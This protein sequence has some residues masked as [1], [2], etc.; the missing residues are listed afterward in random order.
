M[1]RLDMLWDYEPGETL[2][3]SPNTASRAKRRVGSRLELMRR[4]HQGEPS[5]LETAANA[6]P[7]IDTLI[8]YAR[9]LGVELKLAVAGE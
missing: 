9:A 1:P 8:R 3:P 2:S 4:H 6:N 7:T 5:R